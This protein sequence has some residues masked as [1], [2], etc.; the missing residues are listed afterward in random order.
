MKLIATTLVES[1][2]VIIDADVSEKLTAVL[3]KGKGK[4]IVSIN[5]EDVFSVSPHM[6]MLR[7]V[8][9]VLVLYDGQELHF[10]TLAGICT[11]SVTVGRHVRYIEQMKEKVAVTYSDQGMYDD[12][13]GKGVIVVVGK[14]GTLT[15]QRAF[16]ERYGLQYDI[17]FAK[18]KPYACLSYENNTIIHFNEQFELVKVTECPFEVGNVLAMS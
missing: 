2:R 5:D 4:C 13:I 11:Q 8:G 15:S 9:S 1:E 14:D 6:Y 7:I 10:Y 12:P 18:V 3:F 17:C 16:A